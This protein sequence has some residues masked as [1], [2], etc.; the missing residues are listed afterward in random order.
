MG[1]SD[2]RIVIAFPMLEFAD[3]ASPALL[4]A[5][6]VLPEGAISEGVSPAYFRYSEGK[7]CDAMT[8]IW[9]SESGLNS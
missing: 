9:G 1:S 3:A 5:F 7:E 2:G 8:A 4:L 6:L